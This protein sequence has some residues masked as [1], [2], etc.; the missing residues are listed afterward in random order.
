MPTAKAADTATCS[1]IDESRER[2]TPQL[3][4]EDTGDRLFVDSGRDQSP[5]IATAARDGALIVR[6]V[7]DSLVAEIKRRSI[8]VLTIDPFVSCHE[9]RENDNTAQDMI[10]KEWGRVAEACNCAVHLIDHTRKMGPNEGE[11]T[12]ESARGGKAKTDACR[13]VRAVSRMTKEE[14]EK[15]GVEN[16]RLYFRTFNDKANLQPPADKSGW[17]RLNSVALG[18]GRGR[19]RSARRGE[20]HRRR[21]AAATPTHPGPSGRGA[22]TTP[23]PAITSRGRTSIPH[24]RHPRRRKPQS[25]SRSALTTVNAL[26]SYAKVADDDSLRIMAHRI[27]ARAVRRTGELL[28]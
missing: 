6:P 8:D 15:A 16:H 4:S 14:G 1:V 24:L 19:R 9:A 12:T 13:V 25:C 11:V 2:L 22:V 10:V 18:N 26:A 23:A 27:R 17:F 28:K 21:I 20:T 3:S 5:V 7:V